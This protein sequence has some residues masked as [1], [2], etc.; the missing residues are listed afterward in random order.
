MYNTD[1]YNCRYFNNIKVDKNIIT[2]SSTNIKKI[3]SEYDYYYYLPNKLKM[4]FV[5]PFNFKIINDVASYNMEKINIKNSAELFLSGQLK[6]N[7]FISIL[8]NIS[9][10]KNSMPQ[11]LNNSIKQSEYL[12]IEKTYKRI[13]QIQHNKKEI[14]LFNRI[15]K[16]YEYFI[17]YRTNWD[18]SISHGDLCLSNILWIDNVSMIKFI[19]PRGA[20]TKNDI[21][22][23]NY[24]DLAKLSHSIDGGYESII[25]ET[26]NKNN[27]LKPILDNYL[28][29]NGIIYE[30][31]K[32]YEASLFLSMVPLHIDKPNNILQFEDVC[33]TILK[34]VGF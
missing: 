24:Y 10:F 17:K 9:L 31:L 4:Y 27:I 14:D 28:E 11:K 5:Q 8:D 33:D 1:Q 15:K 23:D 7:S 26:K 20:E 30:L 34:K 19:D 16:A 12:V 29:S 21:F 2:K 6:E 3:K 18:L 13:L 22:M 32:V 25:Y